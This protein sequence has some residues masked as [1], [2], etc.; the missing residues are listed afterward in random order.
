MRY[1]P[2]PACPECLSPEA[3]WEAVCGHGEILSWTVFHR[4]YLPTFPAPHTVITVR[5]AEG[6]LL[7][8]TMTP[9]VPDGLSIGAAVELDYDERP[10]GTVLPT[11]HLLER[12]H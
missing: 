10:D 4:Q 8:G 5:L 1:P 3:S 2:G 6:P 12:E 11:F 7:V 9:D